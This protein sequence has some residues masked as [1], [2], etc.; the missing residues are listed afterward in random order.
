MGTVGLSFG[1]ATSGAGFDV[2]STVTQI[3]AVQQSIETPWKTQLALLKS[4]DTIFTTL[5]SDLSALSTSLRA[6]TDFSGVMSQKQGSSS[7]ANVLSLTAANP[8]A[9][10]GSHT[11]VVTSLAQIS[12]QYS[13]TVTNAADV[14]SGSITIQ[15]G[16]GASQTVTVDSSSNTLAT[17]A[18]AI[19][20][21][22]IGATA[23]V[24]SD[25]KGSR[26]SVVSSTGGAAGALTV[27][28]ALSDDTT[29]A[30][31]AFKV[32]QT[33]VDAQLTVDGVALTSATN[34]V[35]TAIPGVTFQ[36]LSVS[37]SPIQ[38]EIT[39]DNSAVETALTAVVSAYNAVLK[40]IKTQE[41]KDSTGA[42]EPLYGS[43]TL[44]LIQSQLN[45]ALLGG[46]ASGAITNITQLGISAGQD[47][48]LTLDSTTLESA[49]DNNFLDVT[50]FLQN[51]G[52]FGQ[53]MATTLNSLGV[54][55]IQG[56]VYLAQQENTA[57]E[58]SLNKNVSDQEARI[59]VQKASLT[60]E[61]NLAN[62][63]LQSIPTQLDS[64]DKLYSAITGY[65]AK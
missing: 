31:L 62:Q 53:I 63:I 9:I 33:G 61:L 65:N 36:L 41:G 2:A 1:S 34:K 51:T 50:G 23:S 17:L 28:S 46:A 59:A 37:A 12:S 30:A 58:A 27:S 7:D 15:V 25:T 16:L 32:G 14:L 44:A 42:A 29:S 22:G 45:A 18:A 4:Q 20:T 55:S 5:G 48:T 11:V 47:G 19:N 54:D 35:S 24:I 40:D 39:N 43:P 3:L 49:L 64:F 38:V 52:G 21:A 26:L 57:Q 60:T 8:A 13:D 6:L 10:A 56:A